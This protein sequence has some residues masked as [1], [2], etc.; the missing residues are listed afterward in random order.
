LP[1]LI[2]I[3]E[4]LSALAGWLITLGAFGLFGVSLLDSAFVPLPSGPDLIMITLST[5]KPERMLVYALAAAVGSTIGCTLLF[6][7]ARR[8]GSAAL[9]RVG[10]GRRERIENLLG[11]FDLLAVMVPAVLPPP[12]PFKAFVL[13]AGVF[14]LRVERFVI[15]IFI[16][17][18]VRFLVAGWLAVQFG[19]GAVQIIKDHSLKV[20]IVAGA[21]LLLLFGVMIYRSRQPNRSMFGR[22]G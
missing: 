9:S 6:L 21:L 19:E 7:V 17:R 20:L 16:G 22:G 13:G 4:S 11:R 8:A 18:A 2:G 1:A 5:L 14:K 15:A 12:F 10:A 3:K